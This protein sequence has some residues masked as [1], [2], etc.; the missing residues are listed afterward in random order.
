M[1]ALLGRLSF[2]R[3]SILP[4]VVIIALLA[5]LPFAVWEFIQT[6]ELYIFS[7]RFW[8]DLVARF[9]G[10]GRMRFIL[11]PTVAIILGAR[12]G[13]KDRR[14]GSP[15]FL[16]GLMFH[17]AQR[18]ELLRGALASVRNLVL[19]AILLDAISQLLIFRIVHP[20]AALLF[21]PVLIGLPYATSRAL[22][23]R[24]G[25]LRRGNVSPSS[26]GRIFQSGMPGGIPP[27]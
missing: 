22:S 25:Q 2:S 20:G 13:A 1:T 19:V 5:A 21:G 12:D 6:G 18:R 8:P 17:F 10:P 26:R 3:K 7:H 27:I 24:I 9:H 15:P 16:W 11:Q 23:N 4:A 14:Q